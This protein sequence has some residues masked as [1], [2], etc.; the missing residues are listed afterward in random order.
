MYTEATKIN[1]L[2]TT[3]LDVDFY[4]KQASKFIDKYVGY[5]IGFVDGNDTVMP[6]I[7]FDGTGTNKLVLDTYIRNHNLIKIDNTEITPL[8]YPLNKIYTNELVLNVG[9]FNSGYGNINITDAKIGRYIVNFGNSSHDLPEDIETACIKLTI[10]AI[11]SAQSQSTATGSVASETIGA[12]SISYDNSAN[13]TNNN[14]D[15]I[16]ALKILDNYRSFSIE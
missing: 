2:I 10:N 15:K 14:S 6:N 12:Y 1:S 4:I 9:I 11:N 3:T 5:K 13:S 8:L 7:S 16:S